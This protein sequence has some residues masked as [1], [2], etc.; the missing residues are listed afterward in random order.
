MSVTL[1]VEQEIAIVRPSGRLDAHT[2][3]SLG[4]ILAEQVLR[5]PYIVVDMRDVHFIDSSALGILVQG[6]KRYRARGGDLMLAALQQ[7]VRIIFE[8]TRLNNAFPTYP[9]AEQACSAAAER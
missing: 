1:Q 4:A 7:P 8:L 6:L 9:D 3:P 2:A 5:S